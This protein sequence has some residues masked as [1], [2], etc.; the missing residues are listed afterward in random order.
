MNANNE[1]NYSM[2]AEY[3]RACLERRAPNWVPCR[4]LLYGPVL[5]DYPIG[6]TTLVGAGEHECFSSQYG[7]I[8]V[9]ATDGM[10]LGLKP[11][12]FEVIEWRR[13][14]ATGE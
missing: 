6:H 7:A 5:G 9:Q 14:A 13:Y 8:S 10:L 4:V 2:S 1:D 11:A 3:Y 12:E